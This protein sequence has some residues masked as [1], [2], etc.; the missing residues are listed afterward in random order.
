MRDE[1]MKQLLLSTMILFG[2][3]LLCGPHE[4]ECG[5]GKAIEA[6]VAGFPRASEDLRLWVASHGGEAKVLFRWDARRPEQTKEFVSWVTSH[7]GKGIDSF[8]ERHREWRRFDR[9]VREH[10]QLL[11]DFVVWCR[12]HP[13]ASAALMDTPRALHRYGRYYYLTLGDEGDS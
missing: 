12:F 11:C 13:K 4:A 9:I 3:L 2:V 8:V 10:R 1:Q 5:N 7:Q 6:W